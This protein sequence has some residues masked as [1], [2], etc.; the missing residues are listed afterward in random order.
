MAASQRERLSS[1]SS[2]RSGAFSSLYR[3]LDAARR[4]KRG[5]RVRD[6]H[7]NIGRQLSARESISGTRFG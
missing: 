7:Q 1:R 5:P 6:V 3:G 4:R 2:F